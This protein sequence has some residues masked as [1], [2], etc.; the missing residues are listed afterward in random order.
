[1]DG[2]IWGGFGTTG[3]RCTAASRVI[4][5]RAIHREL[6]DRLAGRAGGMRLGYGLEET[7]D[8]GPV[9]RGGQLE[10]VH[11]YVE[12]GSHEGA[13]LGVGG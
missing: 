10:G 8:V 3:Q 11:S 5:H 9:V 4:A 7:T 13:S 6:V 1:M 12:V 2:A